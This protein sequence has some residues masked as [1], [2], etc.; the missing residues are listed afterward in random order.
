MRAGLEYFE[1][2]EQDAKDFAA[3]LATKLGMLALVLTGRRRPARF[4]S[5]MPGSWRATCREPS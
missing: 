1:T 2:F 5:R 4:S 3:F